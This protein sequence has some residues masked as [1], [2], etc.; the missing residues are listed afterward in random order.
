MKKNNSNNTD[1]ILPESMFACSV[2]KKTEKMRKKIA[3]VQG[4]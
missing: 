1:T 2:Q 4:Q 3:E